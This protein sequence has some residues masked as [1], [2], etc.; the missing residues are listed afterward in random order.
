MMFGGALTIAVHLNIMLQSQLIIPIPSYC[1][2]RN[3][4][5]INK[6]F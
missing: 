6:I 1:I 2:P 4:E 5:K 3:E